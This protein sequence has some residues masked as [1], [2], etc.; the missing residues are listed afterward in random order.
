[1]RR[2]FL[3]LALLCLP[4]VASAMPHYVGTCM[5]GGQ[6]L[7]VSNLPGTPLVLASFPQCT[8]TVFFTG[9]ITNAPIF[10][11]NFGTV[12][13]NPFQANADGSFSFYVAS[14]TRV[15]VQM[16][17]AGMPTT[18][19]GD[20][21]LVDT[22]IQS[23]NNAFTG[24]NTMA[25]LDSVLAVDGVKYTTIA[26]AVAACPSIGCVVWVPD[27]LNPSISSTLTIS[28]P[29]HLILGK[30]TLTCTMADP[31]VA[32]GCIVVASDNVEFEGQGPLSLITQ[33]N[34]QNIE[35][36]IFLG[37][38]GNVRFHDFKIDWNDANQTATGGFYTGIRSSAGSHDIR[39]YRT[40]CTRGGDRCIDIRGAN[41]VWIGSDAPNYFHQ[42]GIGVAGVSTRGGSAI[43]VDVDG[44]THSTDG[45]CE[46]NQFEEW[47]DT[48]IKCGND[49][50]HV[51][52]NTLRG[53]AD[54]GNIPLAVESGIDMLGTVIGEAHGNLT[55]NVSNFILG[56]DAFNNGVQTLVPF[57]VD[58][59][60]N[61]FYVDQV[62]LAAT[63]PRVTA[64]QG[65]LAVQLQ[66][67]SFIGNTFI[68]V[69]RAFSGIDGLTSTGNQ[70]KDIIS[71]LASYA[72]DLNQVSGGQLKNFTFS[73]DTFTTSNGSLVTAFNLNSVGGTWAPGTSSFTMNDVDASVTNRITY[74]VGANV[75]VPEI[76]PVTGGVVNIPNGLSTTTIAATT[77]SVSGQ[78]TSTL[79]IGTPPFVVTSTTPVSNLVAGGNSITVASGTATMTTALIGAGACGST[80]TATA[81][82][83]LTTDAIIF[84]FN[85]SVAVNPAELVVSS[86][87][88][89]GNVNFQYCNPSAGGI[90]PT[91]ATLNWRVVR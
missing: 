16:S 30:N 70:H 65:G 9:T 53:R 60:G 56:V 67:I 39:I 59:I 24:V 64:S 40:E 14:G 37:S 26:Q 15:D 79:A 50:V 45:Y 63:D 69:R 87:L 72:V 28:N 2:A 89:V 43:S 21:A 86:W 91:A 46:N 58:V 44:A 68:G 82:G 13:G 18:T 81:T 61:T 78:I 20:V 4:R 48:A 7:F 41:R 3:I 22:M 5:R 77:L 90:T 31:G 25:S 1:L 85:N 11:D 49:R 75:K 6:T 54:F 33:P 71:S 57:A 29:V 32:S 35:T 62:S 47:G 8:V 83:V 73:G 66:R 88:T 38:H 12:L 36:A 10:Q 80:V 74:Q 55:R 51:N 23:L 19:I 17:G 42:T 52:F 76:W 84:S 27:G 34:A